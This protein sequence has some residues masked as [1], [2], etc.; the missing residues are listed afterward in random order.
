LNIPEAITGYDDKVDHVFSEVSSALS[1]YQIYSSMENLDARLARQ[2]HLVLVSFFKLCAYV[3]RYRQGGRRE[4]LKSRINSIVEDGSGL[5]AKLTEF[6][7]VLQQERDVQETL[8]H[9][10]VVET[11]QK[12]VS[13]AKTGEVTHQ[14]VQETQHV[15]QETQKGVQA[16]KDDAGRTKTLMKIRDTLDIPQ[17][18]VLEGKATQTCT[19]IADRYLPG[20]GDWIREN[21][22]YSTWMAPLSKGKGTGVTPL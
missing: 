1:Q 14:V 16:L 12:F 3:K 18:V 6:K 15:A 5:D 17:T 13:F 21:Q 19:N 8:T 11:N 7:R 4:R 2:I 20:T 22:A 9:A 10:T